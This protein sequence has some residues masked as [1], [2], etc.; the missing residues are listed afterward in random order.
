MFTSQITGTTPTG[1][2]GVTTADSTAGR[3]LR[4]L[5][6]AAAADS[7]AAV[8]T[9]GDSVRVAQRQGVEVV[10][11]AQAVVE[12]TG[13][14]PALSRFRLLN[15]LKA[16]LVDVSVAAHYRWP[17]EPVRP[18]DQDL[19]I[20]AVQAD[21]GRLL[22]S[23]TL[24]RPPGSAGARLADPDRPLLVVEEAFG[25]GVYDGMPGLPALRLN[26]VAEVKRLARDQDLRGIAG[27]RVA[28]ETIMALIMASSFA[29]DLSIKAWLGDLEPRVARLLSFLHLR[30]HFVNAPPRPA[31]TSADARYLSHRFSAGQARPFAIWTAE[32]GPTAPR[33]AQV[34]AALALP[35]AA[36]AQ[37]LAALAA[38]S[39]KRQDSRR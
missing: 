8:V 32:L 10:V 38:A 26:Q 35:D 25:V 30:V 29:W 34:Q 24:R 14:W 13:T 3:Y 12:A 21:T 6:E 17:G 4:A 5:T 2:A 36:A 20:L 7:V 15:Y 1:G 22:A 16:G 31:A 23:A 11:A 28:L 39:A 9:C 37:A 19:H 18:G 33:C 27:L